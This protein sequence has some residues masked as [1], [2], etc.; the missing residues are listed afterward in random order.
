MNKMMNGKASRP[1]WAEVLNDWVEVDMP[2]AVFNP[3]EAQQ[4]D[5]TSQLI[6]L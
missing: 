3:Q 6:L 5:K 4:T 1:R 2:C